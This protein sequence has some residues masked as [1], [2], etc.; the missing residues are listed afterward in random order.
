MADVKIPIEFQVIIKDL[1]KSI[2]QNNKAIESL[3]NSVNVL[4]QDIDS[5]GRDSARNFKQVGDSINQTNQQIS[6]LN[7]ETK[8]LREESD[9]SSRSLSQRFNDLADAVNKTS[10]AIKFA[11]K[12]LLPLV[13]TL[14]NSS[15]SG[16]KFA[17][18]IEGAINRV[19]DTILQAVSD[20][21]DRLVDLF[22]AK[23]TAGRAIALLRINR[24]VTKSFKEIRQEVERTE[25]ELTGF[26]NTFL[27][28]AKKAGVFVGGLVAA[29]LALVGTAEAIRLFDRTNNKLNAG[30]TK[31]ANASLILNTVLQG[32]R[33]RSRDAAKAFSTLVN[34][35]TPIADL[36]NLYKT[37][38][39]DA[40]D[41]IRSAAVRGGI[42]LGESLLKGVSQFV[43]TTFK[44][45]LLGSLGKAFLEA[46]KSAS[47]FEKAIFGGLA[48]V[49]VF[50][51]TLLGLSAIL[52][53]SDNL[54]I[55]LTGDILQIIG[56]ALVPLGITV[57]FLIIKLGQFVKSLGD[58][59]V[60]ANVQA[61]E[62]FFEAERAAFIFNRT[63][64][65]FSREFPDLLRN[66]GSLG[67]F[68][69]RLSRSLGVNRQQLQLGTVALVETAAQLGFNTGQIRELIKVSIDLSR[70]YKRNIVE[71]TQLVASAIAGNSQALTGLGIVINENALRTFVYKDSVQILNKNLTEAQQRQAR[72][73]LILKQAKPILGTAAALTST[74]AGL[75]ALV[76]SRL[77][78]ATVSF[79]KGAAV[80]E[81][82]NVGLRASL[83]VLNSIPDPLLSLIGF[84]SGLTGR[85]LQLAGAVLQVAFAVL[86]LR[87]AFVT[88]NTFFATGAFTALASKT[89]PVINKSL[90]ELIKTAGV[91]NVSFASLGDTVRTLG[92]I[93]AAS[94]K[95]LVINF[96]PAS[97]REA[98][99]FFG[100][101]A[102]S[103]K[104][105]L[106]A[107]RALSLFFLTN[108][109]GVTITL[110]AGA[111][112]FATKAIEELNRTSRIIPK[113][114]EA[115]GGIAEDL[116]GRF[117]SLEGIFDRLFTFISTKLEQA[118]GLALIGVLKKIRD[119]VNILLLV[120][121]KV[122]D[123]FSKETR[124]SL[125][126]ATDEIDKFTV[127]L[128]K[129]D[130]QTSKL[131]R[132]LTNLS[133]GPSGIGGLDAAEINRRIQ[134]LGKE[135]ENIGKTQI[136]IIREQFDERIK[137]INQF[138][139]LDVR[140]TE[141]AEKLK[142]QTR[143]DF[144]L[145]LQK[146]QIKLDRE[147]ADLQRRL[148][149]EG[150]R[151]PLG[152]LLSGEGGP[153]QIGAIGQIGAQAF[154]G[155]AG[156]LRFIQDI[157]RTFGNAIADGLGDI[158]SQILGV[159]AQGPDAVRRTIKEFITSIPDIFEAIIT[160]IPEIIP[161]IIES[162]PILV[163]KIIASIPRIITAFI[164]GIPRFIQALVRSIPQLIKAIIE[165]IPQIINE[166]ARNMPQIAIDFVKALIEEA[167]KFVEALIK[168]IAKVGG[169]NGPFSGIAQSL[170]IGG[171]GGGG[172]ILGGV[173]GTV[174]SVVTAPFKAIGKVFGFAEGGL[175]PQ[176]FPQ[177][178]FF[179]RLSSG[180][181]VID[182]SQ[183][184]QLQ[185]F[186]DSQ[187][188][189]ALSG[190][191]ER[192][193]SLL[194]RLG[195]TGSQALTIN[196]RIGERELANVLLD[197]NRRG[198]R[199]A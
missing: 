186:L 58:S 143:L 88:L 61:A 145:K 179:S 77:K 63:L 128:I 87:G 178:S 13:K 2:K 126:A 56:I 23:T 133:R 189:G 105:A 192:L 52:R 24:T 86:V 10:K 130:F 159:L 139:S 171:S 167:P 60:K 152:T 84:V 121:D 176:G 177:D 17:K 151:D 108:P 118:F 35:S 16:E 69:D 146:E 180:E 4:N 73:N 196:L 64:N 46:G 194:E 1:E 81:N 49:E 169:D 157:G 140:N 72:F 144:E 93:G 79:G 98:P 155:Q 188:R 197:L 22:S 44:D 97:I 41:T 40:L 149:F 168:S 106:V 34:S 26:D 19:K 83:F 120:D 7:I 160:S 112:I 9:R 91:V 148:L 37:S 182:R 25:K 111:I 66:V 131:K 59:L 85:L 3:N 134:S 142:F 174:A 92:A 114:Q 136:Q 94:I 154:Q 32:I 18:T 95:R 89:I 109:V 28:V 164:Q 162:V 141:L 82:L 161:A 11:N 12:T 62:S 68:V 99:G 43:G 163:E 184:A 50:G 45:T 156:A 90:I 119:L 42:R 115:F 129:A 175:V 31:T 158:V 170:G 101:L 127:E 15:T 20:I 125:R 6:K 191:D 104:L 100:K 5:L 195:G 27:S 110:I 76:D 198:F 138:A 70:A 53:E 123:L 47:V 165:G 102:A 150:R 54:F 14:L 33:L 71:V 199:T 113:L 137:L 181:F 147:R 187:E 132:N 96:L 103:I 57:Q 193:D 107:L 173:V 185:R 8:R 135:L 29:D 172:G 38:L 122:L 80:V 67:P 36:G 39:I 30:L 74:T 65:N 124:A 153:A 48:R 51:L 75:L 78:E 190:D 117:S 55:K 166:L 183:N 21:Q 116:G